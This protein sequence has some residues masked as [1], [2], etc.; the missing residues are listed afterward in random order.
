MLI[1]RTPN[2]LCYLDSSQ[3]NPDLKQ[4]AQMLN[5]KINKDTLETAQ[6]G[7]TIS[8]FADAL[9]VSRSALSRLLAEKAEPSNHMIAVLTAK[10]PYRFDEIFILEDAA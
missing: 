8:D 9:D 10:L 3:A 7:R 5:V 4:G 6:A 2:F 1:V